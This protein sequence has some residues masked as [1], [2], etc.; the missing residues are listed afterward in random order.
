[1][2]YTGRFAKL[3]YASSL[4]FSNFYPLIFRI[5]KKTYSMF[6]FLGTRGCFSKYYLHALATGTVKLVPMLPISD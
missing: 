2:Y 6:M 5:I 1:M 4:S 3:T